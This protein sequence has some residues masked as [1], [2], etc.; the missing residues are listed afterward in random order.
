MFIFIFLLVAANIGVPPTVN[1]AGEVLIFRGIVATDSEV[2]VICFLLIIFSVITILYSLA[3]Y[4]SLAHGPVRPHVNFIWQ[5][6][7][8]ITVAFLHLAPL[9]GGFFAISVFVQ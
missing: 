6:P 2:P 7:I 3:L 9:I 8:Y 5:R 4:T 1:I